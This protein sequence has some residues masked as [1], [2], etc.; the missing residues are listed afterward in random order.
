MYRLHGGQDNIAVKIKLYD[1]TMIEVA[2]DPSKTTVK[3][4]KQIIASTSK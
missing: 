1:D 3:A 2:L 4:L